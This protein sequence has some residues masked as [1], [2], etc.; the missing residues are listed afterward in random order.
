MTAAIT[1]SS[2]HSSSIYYTKAPFSLSMLKTSRAWHLQGGTCGGQIHTHIRTRKPPQLSFI[3]VLMKVALVC[4]K[5]LWKIDE[6]RYPYIHTHTDGESSL[7]YLFLFGRRTLGLLNFHILLS[8]FAS[9]L[10]VPPTDCPGLSGLK[11]V[12][13]DN[14]L[15]GQA[16]SRA[17]GSSDLSGNIYQ[18]RSILQAVRGLLLN[19]REVISPLLF[20]D[21]KAEG[22]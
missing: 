4:W 22:E 21:T 16:L 7:G 19:L 15:Q 13:G 1:V 14:R 9:F 20:P 10:R 2:S 3:V 18:E 17:T 11:A 8:H 6:W 5:F 12:R